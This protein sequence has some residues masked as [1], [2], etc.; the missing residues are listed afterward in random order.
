MRKLSCIFILLLLSL[1]SFGKNL[2]YGRVVGVNKNTDG[3]VKFIE[4]YSDY[5]K[6]Y[7]F[8]ISTQTYSID[9]G[10][11]IAIPLENIK[12]NEGVYVFYGDVA[13]ASIPPQSQALAIVRNIPQDAMS[14]QYFVVE[15]IIKDKDGVKLQ[16]GNGGLF[17]KLDEKTKLFPYRTKNIVKMKDIRKGS[18]VMVWYQPYASVYPGN[19]YATHLMLLPEIK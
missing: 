14:A 1:S 15:D 2:Y 8:N 18:K 19:T 12:E 10:R 9:S 6:E 13:T 5:Q 16:V 3:S 7:I 4:M 17:I 11:K